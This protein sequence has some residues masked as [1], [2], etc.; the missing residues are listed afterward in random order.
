MSLGLFPLVSAPVAVTDVERIRPV[1]FF[2][3]VFRGE[4]RNAFDD[5]YQSRLRSYQYFLFGHPLS[6]NV[7]Y[8]V[9]ARPARGTAGIRAFGT[10]FGQPVRFE[11]V[12]LEG[13]LYGQEIGVD[14]RERSF[15]EK[16]QRLTNRDFHPTSKGR[17]CFRALETDGILG[18]RIFLRFRGCRLR[19]VRYF[20]GFRHRQV[21]EVTIGFHRSLR[22]AG[23][24]HPR[25]ESF[26]GRI[27]K[28]PSRRP[29]C[30]ERGPSRNTRFTRSR[31][32]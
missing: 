30:R 12:E 2:V 10:L 23:N 9:F 21:R 19:P 4:N 1:T 16:V 7:H 29:C 5:G 25:V 20:G 15:V 6:Q 18:R 13:I 14:F 26:I 31:K 17:G 8:G 22:C 32:P 27:L 3:H 11:P 28:F 24:T